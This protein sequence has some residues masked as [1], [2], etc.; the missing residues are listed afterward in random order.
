ML[1]RLAS[2]ILFVIA[3]TTVSAKLDVL[4]VLSVSQFSH[5][6]FYFPQAIFA[7]SLAT[8][9]STTRFVNFC[10]IKP[11]VS[12]FVL[13]NLFSFFFFKIT[14][15]P[16]L[17]AHWGRRDHSR[18]LERLLGWLRSWWRGP[19]RHCEWYFSYFYYVWRRVLLEFTIPLAPTRRF[20]ILMSLWPPLPG[21]APNHLLTTGVLPLGVR[22]IS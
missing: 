5:R 20:P 13:P 3:P 17:V 15:Y 14:K 7:V 18:C 11:T 8:P 12:C 2:K 10:P 6:Q 4:P 21:L 16:N 9:V 22:F 19:R 1:F